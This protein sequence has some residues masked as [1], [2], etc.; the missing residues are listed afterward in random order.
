M[1]NAGTGRTCIPALS[2]KTCLRCV[3]LE[4][5]IEC[6]IGSNPDR[7]AL[8]WKAVIEYRYWHRAEP[9]RST[10]VQAP[11]GELLGV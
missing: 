10:P 2:F 8:L 5:E 11:A 7:D 1:F 6:L 4:G 9:S 3:E